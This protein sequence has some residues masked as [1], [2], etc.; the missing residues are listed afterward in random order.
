V[1]IGNYIVRARTVVCIG[2]VIVFA[3]AYSLSLQTVSFYQMRKLTREHPDLRIMPKP[4]ID[5]SIYSGKVTT[6]SA[7]GYQFDLPWDD[8]K[9]TTE[10]SM[11]HSVHFHRGI[12]V[13]LLDPRADTAMPGAVV[14]D[15]PARL[16]E[17]IL[18]QFGVAGQT[19]NYQFVSNALYA[20]PDEP[21]T[22]SRRRAYRNY[23]SLMFKSVELPSSDH[24]SKNIF[25]VNTQ[26]YRGFQFGDPATSGVVKIKLFDQR[27]QQIEVL[28]GIK[29]SA[30]TKPVQSEINRLVESLRPLRDTQPGQANA[31][32]GPR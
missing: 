32:P 7:F 30:T 28:V 18:R 6:Y 12:T 9:E 3:V 15:S 26:R 19:P 22:F 23:M 13:T 11:F 1:K 4:L 21:F 29:P 8:V 5:P 10:K 31:T 16:K 2:I 14:R 17:Q 25:V 20:N 27:D 24:V